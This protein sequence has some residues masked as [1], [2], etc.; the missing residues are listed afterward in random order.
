M[1]TQTHILGETG[2][3][4][5]YWDTGFDDFQY[6]AFPAFP[7]HNI[8]KDNYDLENVLVSI[9]GLF[10]DQGSSIYFFSGGFFKLS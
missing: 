10:V 2:P 3:F 6:D 1:S 8:V 7:F 5:V 9:I 4:Q